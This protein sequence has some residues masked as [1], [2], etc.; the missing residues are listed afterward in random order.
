MA[1]ACND[2]QQLDNF[3]SLKVLQVEFLWG[4]HAGNTWIVQEI[5]CANIQSRHGPALSAH[6][7]G[8][9]YGRLPLL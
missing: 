4:H 5:S 2:F 9:Q 1:L 8:L 3:V 6:A 7:P